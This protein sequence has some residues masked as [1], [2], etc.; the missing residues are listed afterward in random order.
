M[1]KGHGGNRPC[2]LC[3]VSGLDNHLLVSMHLTSLPYLYFLVLMDCF[4]L[5]QETMK[6]LERRALNYLTNEFLL[7]HGYRLTSITFC[8]ENE[9]QVSEPTNPNP[10][11]NGNNSVGWVFSEWYNDWVCWLATVDGL[12]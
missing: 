12:S 7:H 6:P 3:E 9:E 8:D 10:N 2:C 5:F 11:I 1:T 4:S